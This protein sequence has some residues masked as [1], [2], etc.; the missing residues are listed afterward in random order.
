MIGQR[1]AIIASNE[2]SFFVGQV[3]AFSAS[4]VR[5]AN[6]NFF[7]VPTDQPIVWGNVHINIQG[8]TTSVQVCYEPETVRVRLH[9]ALASTLWQSCDIVLTENNGG[10]PD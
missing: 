9:Q 1:W 10:A 7:P 3:D 6:S 5:P 8:G 2:L 4:P